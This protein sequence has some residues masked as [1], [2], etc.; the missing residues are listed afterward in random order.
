MFTEAGNWCLVGGD[1]VGLFWVAF[2]EVISFVE[3][4][5][6]FLVGV[7]CEDQGKLSVIW[8]VRVKVWYR[9]VFL[10]QVQGW[11]S[12]EFHLVCCFNSAAETAVGAVVSGRTT[13]V[14]GEVASFWLLFL[15]TGLGA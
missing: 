15:A 9:R 5:R 2:C 13:M 8:L 4:G 14:P 6:F 10:W 3:R 1:A 12:F 7:F 11:Y